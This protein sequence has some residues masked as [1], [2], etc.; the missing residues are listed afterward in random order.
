MKSST[1]QNIKGLQLV[2]NSLAI[3]DGSLEIA[4]NVTISQDNIVTKRRGYYSD[5]NANLFNG[6]LVAETIY[7]IFDYQNFVFFVNGSQILQKVI[8]KV[9]TARITQ[10]YKVFVSSLAHGLGKFGN[11]VRF[12]IDPEDEFF[13]LLFPNRAADFTGFLTVDFAYKNVVAQKT[14]NVVTVT[15][16]NTYQIGDVINVTLLGF[17]S[18]PILPTNLGFKTVTSATL[19]Q[20]TYSETGPD[21]SFLFDYDTPNSFVVN[22]PIGIAASNGTSNTNA[23]KF[24]YSKILEGVGFSKTLAD[25]ELKNVYA[26]KSNNNCYVNGTNGLVKIERYDLPY[27]KAGILP[28]LSVE[29]KLTTNSL[30]ILAGPIKPGT[31]VAY[32]SVFGR[33]DASG[34]LILSAPSIATLERISFQTVVTTNQALGALNSGGTGFKT[35]TV[36]V[37]PTHGLLSVVNSIYFGTVSYGFSL[38][39]IQN[40]TYV[41]PTVFT[42]LVSN[43]IIALESFSFETAKTAKLFFQIPEGMTVQNVWQLYR[44]S[45]SVN[46][47]TLPEEDYKLVEEA[48]L[49]ANDL[50]LKT[51]FYLDETDQILLNGSPQLYTNPT[52]EGPLQVNNIPPFCQDM[53]VFKNFTFYAN[54]TDLRSLSLSILAPTLIA[55]NTDFFVG[56]I[57][58]R[59]V[60]NASNGFL[61]NDTV[62]LSATF[63]GGVCT[64]TSVGH[65]FSSGAIF[66]ILTSSNAVIQ[67]GVYSVG[68][69]P[70]AN[71]FTFTCPPGTGSATLTLTFLQDGSQVYFIKNYLPSALITIAESIALTARAIVKAVNSNPLSTV[72]AQYVSNPSQIPGQILFTAKN[73]SESL[74]PDFDVTTTANGLAFNPTLSSAAQV[75]A[76]STLAVLS[77][78]TAKQNGIRISKFN[79]PESCPPTNELLVGSQSEP[80]LRIIP[81]RDT[82]IIIKTDGIFRILGESLNNFSVYLMDSSV[83][84]KTSQSVSLLNNSV[85]CLSTQGVV[86]ISDNSVQIVSRNIEPALI[87]ILRDSELEKQTSSYGYESERVYALC[88]IDRKKKPSGLPAVI[89]V[90]NYI[91][92]EWTTHTGENALFTTAYVPITDDTLLLAQGS[93]KASTFLNRERKINMLTDFSGQDYALNSYVGN[94]FQA[95]G[96]LGTTELTLSFKFAHGFKANDLCKLSFLDFGANYPVG[97]ASLFVTNNN[98]N[99]VLRVLNDFSLVINFATP[100]TEFKNGSGALNSIYRNANELT[101]TTALQ[102]S[103]TDTFARLFSNV[104]PYLPLQSFVDLTFLAKSIQQQLFNPF[105]LN[106]RTAQKVLLTKINPSDTF[107]Q[108]TFPNFG[109]GPSLTFESI[110]WSV[111]SDDVTFLIVTVPIINSVLQFVPEA[112]DIIVK[113]GFINVIEDVFNPSTALKNR[114]GLKLRDTLQGGY[115]SAIT[116]YKSYKS[117]IK[118][119]PLTFGDSGTLKIFSEFQTTFRNTKSCTSLKVTF[120][121]DS[122]GTSAPNVWNV[123]VSDKKTDLNYDGLGQLPF[124]SGRFGGFSSIVRELLTRPSTMLRQYIPKQAGLGTF[125][126]PTIEHNVAGEPIEIQ[127]ITVL[128]RPISQRTTR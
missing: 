37:T 109:V 77:T 115:G 90:Y 98:L 55:N 50:L 47:I 53:G 26:I 95:S 9:G 107:G 67:A 20:F 68:N 32:K 122:A 7:R 128:N 24:S 119:A 22:L 71:T 83:I 124:G 54:Y 44:T 1:I 65:G 30:G 57:S 123:K 14:A 106:K 46:S 40:A 41:S 60:S 80:I 43:S 17:S 108:I 51:V 96:S 12:E 97:N 16:P 42:F 11:S 114:F 59:F 125:I 25:T 18:Q 87:E 28:A 69:F 111:S 52:A 19:T 34:N 31:Q 86:Q 63:S 72:F 82:L 91:T 76:N 33:R 103:S 105:Q 101:L 121:T 13:A 104:I 66:Q 61:G 113:N 73:Y 94:V 3:R 81:L 29:I 15:Q 99:A 49:T 112:G 45:G 116:L 110:S 2:Q 58:F 78:K 4:E 102:T 35:V 6:L 56:G 75:T 39:S 92:Q 70:T 21:S 85:F 23:I 120:A 93:Y 127:S 117:L 64:V 84:C 5:F 88:T 100:S 126:Q 62:I 10:P 36:T 79:E 74:S 118:F 38:N 8:G 89:Y 48:N 27:L